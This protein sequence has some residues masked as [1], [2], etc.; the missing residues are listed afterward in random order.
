[1]GL[2]IFCKTSGD[3][4]GLTPQDRLIGQYLFT[5][6]SFV[7]AEDLHTHEQSFASCKR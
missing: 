4:L 3:E 5:F 6:H 7:Q 1:M 2:E